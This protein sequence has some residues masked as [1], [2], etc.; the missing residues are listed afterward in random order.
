MK[1]RECCIMIPAVEDGGSLKT[2]D[3]EPGTNERHQ[4][5]ALDI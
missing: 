5:K 4:L 2:A 1:K 3:H